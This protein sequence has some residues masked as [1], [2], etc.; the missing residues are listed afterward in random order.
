MSLASLEWI[1]PSM[2]GWLA[3]ASLPWWLHRWRIRRPPEVPWAAMRLL[4]AALD[5]RT[6]HLRLQQWLLLI[7]R[8]S[9]LLLVALAAAQP[10]WQQSPGTAVR[11]GRTHHVLLVD[12]SYSMAARRVGKEGMAG[13]S[14]LDEAR[15]AAGQIIRSAPAGDLFT[16]LGWADTEANRLVPRATAAAAASNAVERLDLVHAPA[17]LAA[18]LRAALGAV[19]QAGQTQAGQTQAG[20]TQPEVARQQIWVLTDLGRNTWQD[21]AYADEPQRLCRQLAALGELRVCPVGGPY[22]SA[23]A[24]PPGGNVAV[25]QLTAEPPLALV[26]APLTIEA[27]LRAFGP[28]ANTPLQVELSVDGLLVER[29]AVELSADTEARVRYETRLAAPG[30]HVVRVACRPH[31]DLPLD[32]QR[33]RLVE[34]RR[35]VRLLCLEGQRQAA[36]DLIRALT[37]RPARSRDSGPAPPPPPFQVDRLPASRLAEANLPE[38]DALLVCNVAGFQPAE[39]ERLARYARSGGAVL[40]FLGDRVVPG[41]DHGMF[42]QSTQ[43]AAAVPSGLLPVAIGPAVEVQDIHWDPLGYRHPLLAPFRDHPQAGLASVTVAKYFKLTRPASS[44]LRLSGSGSLGSGSLGSRSSGPRSSGPQPAAAAFETALAFDTGDPAIVLGPLG[45]GQVAVVALPAALASR[46]S[47]GTPWSSWPVNPCFLPMVRE[48]LNQVVG[49]SGQDPFNRLVGEPLFLPAADLA[50]AVKTTQPLRLRTPTGTVLEA[51]D[52]ARQ[53]ADG[54]RLLLPAT[55]KRGIYTLLSGLAPADKPFRYAVNLDPFQ[56]ATGTGE[57][58]LATVEPDRLPRALAIRPQPS[59]RGGQAE[60][61]L[62][63]TLFA[64]ALGLSLLELLLAWWLGR[65]WE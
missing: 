12:Q 32:D 17:R 23:A 4:R 60:M 40:F 53:G 62:A 8:T 52:S 19:R 46:T 55:R 9:I 51:V 22:R 27:A 25:T 20:Q 6:R 21:A 2:L 29:R 30:Q 11:S 42:V 44:G 16:V 41:Q 36:T 10:V 31:D 43:V 35:Q 24:A 50:A 34:A 64:A 48:L 45:L 38:Y 65:G 15:A 59:G 5:D 37:A 13:N 14:R 1:S 54:S 28:W 7:L 3:A 33:W 61:S 39:A 49:R 26:E 56:P 58:D 47:A 63:G 57:S 18:G